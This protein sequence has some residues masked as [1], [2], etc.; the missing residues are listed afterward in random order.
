MPRV[1]LER[2]S[3]NHFYEYNKSNCCTVAPKVLPTLK[4]GASNRAHFTTNHY[5]RPSIKSLPQAAS[6]KA[7]N[8]DPQVKYL[9]SLRAIRERAKVVGDVADSG[10]LRHFE[11]RKDKLDDAVDFVASVIKVSAQDS[12][13]AF[14]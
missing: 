3:I 14:A 7:C 8:M 9:L 5:R 10:N 11:L 4:F 6:T 2:T 1:G 12:L 13:K